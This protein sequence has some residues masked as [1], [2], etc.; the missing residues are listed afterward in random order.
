[1]FR[2]HDIDLVEFWIMISS[3][4]LEKMILLRQKDSN[5]IIVNN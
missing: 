5:I 1:M 2:L 3:Q 4:I